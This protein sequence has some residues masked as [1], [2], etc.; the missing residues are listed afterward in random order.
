[1]NFLNDLYEKDFVELKFT[2]IKK[3]YDTPNLLVVDNQDQEVPIFYNDLQG[4][5]YPEFCQNHSCLVF[6]EATDH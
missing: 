1:M 5:I 6:E 3:K 2:L 4:G